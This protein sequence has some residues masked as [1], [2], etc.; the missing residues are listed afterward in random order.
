[1]YL[2]SSDLDQ[3]SGTMTSVAKNL[4]SLQLI[5]VN[6]SDTTNEVHANI[7][8]SSPLFDFYYKHG[9]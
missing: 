3:L 5:S 4:N 6:L 9:E 1:M 8:S 7:S 2:F